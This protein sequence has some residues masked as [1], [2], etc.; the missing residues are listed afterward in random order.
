M[1]NR[2]ANPFIFP[3]SKAERSPMIT[4]TTQLFL[5]MQLITD[6]FEQYMDNISF[7]K[8]AEPIKLRG[9]RIFRKQNLLEP[10]YVYIARGTELPDFMARTT[11]AALIS[12]GTPPSFYLRQGFSVLTLPEN[13]DSMEMLDFVQSIFDELL[14]WSS[15]LSCALNLDAP[16]EELCKIAYEQFKNPLFIHDTNFNILACPHRADGM[17]EWEKD[18]YSGRDMLPITVINDFK[19]DPEYIGTLTTRGAQM[20]SELQ[21]GYRILYVNLWNEYNQYEGR[22]CIDELEA[23]I[24]P[25]HFLLAEYFAWIVHV[26]INRRNVFTRNDGNPFG[27]FLIDVLEQ[28]QTDAQQIAV[29]LSRQ[30]WKNED[31]YVCI[32][33]GIQNRDKSVRSISSTCNFLR[34]QLSGSY[35][36]PY[37]E[38]ILVVVNLAFNRNKL[39]NIIP[40]LSAVVREGLFICGVSNPFTPFT[41][42]HYYYEQAGIALQYG[43]RSGQ[44]FW[45]YYYDDCALQY[46]LHA[47]TRTLPARLLCSHKILD[48]L[49]Y[50]EANHTELYPTLKT[51]LQNHQ[52]AVK[53]AKDLFIHRSTLFYRLDR[54]KTQMNINLDNPRE[55]LYLEIS[56]LLLDG[57]DIHEPSPKAN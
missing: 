52:N 40:H 54:L 50:D 56:F 43:M 24:M 36:L 37:M 42:L 10:G 35:S 55:R 9:V 4:D 16:L 19:V 22:L 6:R 25:S 21:R 31:E 32:R 12:I 39:S 26:W 47:A 44:M 1:S 51:Y 5:D 23:S 41:D 17:T 2:S 45:T 49:A 11:S 38:E 48:I 7:K 33:L 30:E 28:K 34:A 18:P 3:H 27:I 14:D 46:L 8:G 15:R 20:F 53:T 57:E 13:C 29:R